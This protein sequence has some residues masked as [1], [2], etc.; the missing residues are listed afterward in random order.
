MSLKMASFDRHR[1]TE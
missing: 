1:M